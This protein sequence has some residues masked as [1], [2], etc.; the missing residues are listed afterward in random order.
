MVV[1]GTV[2]VAGTVVLVAGTVV[3]WAMVVG[4][5]VGTVVVACHDNNTSTSEEKDE[6]TPSESLSDLTLN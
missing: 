4:V 3:V 6:Y 5:V 1:G 2:V